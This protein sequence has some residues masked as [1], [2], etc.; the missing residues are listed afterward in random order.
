L[1]EP[2]PSVM[3]FRWSVAGEDWQSRRFAVA[4][5]IP[6]DFDYSRD[7]LWFVI[8]SSG[9][10]LLVAESRS[11]G[12]EYLLRS[13]ESKPGTWKGLSGY[14]ACGICEKES[15]SREASDERFGGSSL[16]LSI[17]ARSSG[18]VPD[19]ELHSS[20][21]VAP[22]CGI[23]RRRKTEVRGSGLRLSI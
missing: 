12:G 1:I 23:D 13:L 8:C 4:S 22:L 20:Q 19:P 6:R 9:P 5:Q 15:E 21:L 10:P 3:Q 2:V 16:R 17:R 14:S 18:D 7:S 11:K